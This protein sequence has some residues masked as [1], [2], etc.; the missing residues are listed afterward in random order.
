MYPLAGITPRAATNA[1]GPSSKATPPTVHPLPA[2]L[3]MSTN[4]R[5]P[6]AV[7]VARTDSPGCTTC[8]LRVSPVGVLTMTG[9]VGSG[10]DAGASVGSVRRLI[11]SST[12][13]GSCAPASS[14]TASVS[15]NPAATPRPMTPHGCGIHARSRHI[16]T[17]NEYR[18]FCLS[19]GPYRRGH[20]AIQRSRAREN[21]RTRRTRS[22][23]RSKRSRINF[24]EVRGARLLFV[25]RSWHS[26]LIHKRAANHWSRHAHANGAESRSQAIVDITRT[27]VFGD[28]CVAARAVV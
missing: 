22:Y 26:Q 24:D 23:D 1:S 28:Y 8:T 18:S 12:D 13:C 27:D 15:S 25:R 19:G 9:S 10:G 6:P 16:N 11:A 4:V 3:A 5:P 2:R 14:A 21:R 20:E 17:T 7:I